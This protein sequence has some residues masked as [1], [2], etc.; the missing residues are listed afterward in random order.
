MDYDHAGRL[1][2]TVKTIY[3][4]PD[5]TS[6]AATTTIAQNDYNELGQLRNKKWGRKK[7]STTNTPITRL[8]PS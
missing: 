1:L 4:N 8:K 5:G 6:I 3:N 7:T 2:K